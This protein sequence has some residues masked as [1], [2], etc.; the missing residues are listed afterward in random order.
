MKIYTRTGDDGT[1]SLSGGRRVPKY[2]LRVDAYGSVDELI[3]WVG[4][5][6]S[7]KENAQRKE[8]L[9]YIEDQLMRCAAAL[10]A[11]PEISNSTEIL[12]DADSISVLEKEIDT[13]EESLTPLKNFILPGGEILISYCHIARCVCRRAER[14]VLTLNEAESSPRV[15]NKFL[16]RLSDYL[17]VLSRKLSLELDNEEIKWSV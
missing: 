2:S 3:A 17:F 10:A 9:I 15:I 1:T 12:P 13:M 14:S 6:R 4:L 8:L 16:N 7:F 11:D 5:L